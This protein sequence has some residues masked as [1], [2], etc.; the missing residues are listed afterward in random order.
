[1]TVQNNEGANDRV[2]LN[3]VP[4]PNGKAY[5]YDSLDAETPIASADAYSPDT[6]YSERKVGRADFT[7]LDLN[8]ADGRLYYTVAQPGS[9]AAQSPRYSVAIPLE[10]DGSNAV[11]AESETCLLYTSPPQARMYSKPVPVD[12]KADEEVLSFL[13]Q[14]GPKE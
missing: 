10:N 3:N 2:T 1:M 8:T 13:E 6:S 12:E 4:M 7:G 11:T 14:D 9:Y 5:L